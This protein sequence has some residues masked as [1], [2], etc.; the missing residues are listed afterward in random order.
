MVGMEYHL[1]GIY[2]RSFTNAVNAL[3]VIDDLVFTRH[4]ITLPDLVDA[5]R[6]NYQGEKALLAQ[7]KSAPKWGTDDPLADR[8]AL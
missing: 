7:I 6:R 4:L 1:P 2:E 5:M 3:A 8:W